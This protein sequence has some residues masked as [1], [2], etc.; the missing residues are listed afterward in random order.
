MKKKSSEEEL[1][2][3]TKKNGRKKDH[4]YLLKWKMWSQNKEN[5]CELKQSKTEI[6]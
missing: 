4:H 5:L 2:K 1:T 3:K 6:N